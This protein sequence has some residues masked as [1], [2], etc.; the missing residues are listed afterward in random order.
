MAILWQIAKILELSDHQIAAV[1]SP[2]GHPW[3]PPDASRVVVYSSTFTTNAFQIYI[4]EDAGL[5]YTH[6]KLKPNF[7]RKDPPMASI[8]SANRIPCYLVLFALLVVPFSAYPQTTLTGA[9]WFASTSNGSTSVAQ[10]YADGASN[11]VGGDQWYDLWLALDPDASSPVNGP[12]DSEAGIDIALQPDHT[13]KYYIFGTGPCC[14]LSYSGL[15]LFFD[16]RSTTPGISVF[17]PLSGS[18]FLPDKSP[19]L[20]LGGEPVQGSGTPFH[21]S[22]GVMVVLTEYNW[23]SSGTPPGDVCQ[24]FAF[25]PAPGDI[26]SA[27]GSFTLLTAEAAALGLSQVNGAPGSKITF[28]GG[29]FT[30]S[31]TVNIYLGQIAAPALYTVVADDKGAFDFTAVEPPYHYGLT[32]LFAVGQTSGHIGAASF[33]VIPAIFMKPAVAEPVETVNVEGV[34]F[35]AGEQVYIYWSD[36]RAFVGS[37]KADSH[38]GFTGGEAL[39]ITIPANVSP[40]PNE[41]FA[42][43]Q[44][45]G[46]IG[47][48]TIRV[49]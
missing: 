9:M 41:V 24:A 30:P 2:G 1:E 28:S 42:I 4:A 37:T 26:P 5:A 38:G 17:G 22:K 13:Y 6:T 35:G 16:G 48:G 40:G 31:E 46:A 21:I 49:N 14:T 43:G 3:H 29:G 18:S 8:T 20:T 44:T 33:S 11:T 12:S 47:I 15:N 32:A 23:N 45:T 36:P 25:E 7:C 27:F 34:G 39:P 19:T 10:A